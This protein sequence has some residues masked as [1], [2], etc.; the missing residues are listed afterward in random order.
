LALR[1]IHDI[2]DLI[3]DRLIK[4]EPIS[5]TYWEWCE[6]QYEVSEFRPGIVVKTELLARYFK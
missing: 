6:C 2:A 5:D 3:T 4:Q 1:A